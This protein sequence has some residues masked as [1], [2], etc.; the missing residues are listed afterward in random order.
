MN[1]LAKVDPAAAR[2]LT[3]AVTAASVGAAG[4]LT[5][6]KTYAW[7]AGGS[8][9]VLAS[10]ADSAL[11]VVAAL[12]TFIAV[13]VAAAPPDAEHRFGHGKAE[14]FSSLLQAGLVF[15][16]A[17][18][19][20]QEAVRRLLAPTAVG[21]ADAS[22]VVIAASLVVTIVLLILQSY[23]LRRTRSVAVSGDRAHYAADLAANLAALAG[24]ALA[25]LTG[26]A[27][28]DAGAGLLVAAWLVAGAVK[29]L[30]EAAD[31]LM[32]HELDDQERRAILQCVRADP[33]VLGVHD[34]RTRA[35]GPGIYIQMHVELDPGLNLAE[36]HVIVEAA[37]E[38]LMEAFPTA[39]VIIHA[40]PT[41][42][43]EP[44]G[45]FGREEI[46]APVSSA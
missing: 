25:R 18:L 40:D 21:A 29:V 37:E 7:W 4:F 36:T 35:S 19:V 11:D 30:R 17:A 3:F 12:A 23:V 10:L 16:T 5:A 32:D 6:V 44:L 8:V 2:R 31:H 28:F 24:L 20:G 33:R 42:D 13:R 9:A 1:A 43:D 45:R 46:S 27:R 15:A 41:G 14:A 38:R 39:D 22:M 26:D 34:L